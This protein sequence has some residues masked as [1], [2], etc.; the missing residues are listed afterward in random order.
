LN[1]EFA[2]RASI[3][4]SEIGSPNNQKDCSGHGTQVASIIAGTNVGVAKLAN[5][6]AVRILDCDGQ[7]TNSD[8]ISAIHWVLSNY[9]KPAV[10]NLSVGGPPSKAVDEAVALVLAEN[11]PVVVAAGNGKI[12]ACNLSPSN[13]TGAITVAASTE[14]DERAR[15]SNY[16][17]C[18]DI[19]APGVGI[20]TAV[21]F[22]RDPSGWSFASGTS[23]AAPFVT[24]VIA[25]IL[26]TEGNIPLKKLHDILKGWGVANVLKKSTLLGSPNML[27]LAAPYENGGDSG[28]ELEFK[29]PGSLPRHPFESMISARIEIFLIFLGSIIGVLVVAVTGIL[30]IKQPFLS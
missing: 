19:F 14:R 1:L 27:L 24:G 17:P 23:M 22:S 3:V 11:I 5:I 12:D 2:G 16:G 4:H 9:K 30:S 7:G 15:F 18:V 25:Q 21:D 28:D 10:I 26:E 29:K 13:S 8:L 6:K 20:L